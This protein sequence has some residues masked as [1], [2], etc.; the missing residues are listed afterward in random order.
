MIQLDIRKVKSIMTRKL[1]TQDLVA[2]KGKFTTA[3]LSFWLSEKRVPKIG[4][5][6]KLAKALDVPP[7]EIVR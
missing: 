5:I 7:E 2:K 6:K 4:S 3:S 1:L